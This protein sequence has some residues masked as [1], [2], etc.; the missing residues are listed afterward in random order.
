MRGC[1]FNYV[2]QE[3]NEG[4]LSGSLIKELIEKT[5]NQGDNGEGE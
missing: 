1:W 2:G 4:D 3:I 5:M